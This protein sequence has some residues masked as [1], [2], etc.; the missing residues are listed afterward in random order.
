MNDTFGAEINLS[1]NG[2]IT[3]LVSQIENLEDQITVSNT[4]PTNP[5]VDQLW[6]DTS[7]PENNVIYRWDGTSWVET[8]LSQSD[9][10][11]MNQAIASSQSSISQLSN[12]VATK[13]ST[14][15]Y[16]TDIATKADTGWV[17][18]Q[19]TSLQVQTATDITN[20]FN[21]STDYVDSAL[22]DYEQLKNDVYSWQKFSANGLEIGK[23][24]S[25]FKT[26]LSNTKLAFTQNDDEVAYISDSSMYITNARVTNTLSVG[27][28]TEGW[29]DWVMTSS[30][31][32]MKWKA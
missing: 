3:S 20:I 19:L 11:S 26:K 21:Q 4:A 23:S 24:D 32:A 15:Q 27:T 10:I 6:M 18:Q 1:Q 31:L 16:N 2:A 22:G 13:V 29:F 7:D 17:S 8:T 12:E 5:T 30:G 28:E 9:I 25:E 14:T